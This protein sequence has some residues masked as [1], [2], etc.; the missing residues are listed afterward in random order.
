MFGNEIAVFR[1]NADNCQYHSRHAADRA[2]KAEWLHLTTQ[3]HWL[4]T[5]A[6]K[7]NGVPPV[8]IVGQD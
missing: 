3:W 5:Q 1:R 6:E 4:A 8:Q 7:L 2:I